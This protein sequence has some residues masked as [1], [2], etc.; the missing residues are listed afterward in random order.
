MQIG[1][2]AMTLTATVLLSA[3]C[4]DDTPAQVAGPGD[5]GHIHDLVETDDGTLLVAS[6]TGLYRIDD[7]ATATL[8]GTEQHDLMSMAA[9]NDTIYASGHPDL[10]LEQ[11]RVEGLPAHLGLAESDDLGRTWTVDPNLLGRYDFHA[12]QPTELGLYA[13]DSLGTIRFR[14]D[15]GEW[16]DLGSLE[17]RDLAA[18]PNDPRRLVATDWDGQLWSSDDGAQTWA[19]AIGSPGAIE[20]EWLN[21]D[22]LFAAAEDGSIHRAS[23]PDGP[24]IGVATAPADVETLYAVNDRLWITS[25]GGSIH[26]SSDDGET[27][28]PVYIPPTI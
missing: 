17:A 23:S 24:W 27:W 5:L 4:A 6:H 25:H 15:E 20:V 16:S 19:L 22:T 13:A 3:A 21:S 7:I 8:V 26:I 12:L 11:Y 2:L 18:D 28:Q 9:A 10:R 14:D 1:K